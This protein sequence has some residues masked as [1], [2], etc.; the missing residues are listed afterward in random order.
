[1]PPTADWKGGGTAA[2]TDNALPSRQ[3]GG[4][5]GRPMPR[6]RS[7]PNGLRKVGPIAR[8]NAMRRNAVA[9]GFIRRFVAPPDVTTSNRRRLSV[10]AHTHQGRRRFPWLDHQARLPPAS[11]RAFATAVSPSRRCYVLVLSRPLYHTGCYG[12]SYD[13]IRTARVKRKT[14]RAQSFPSC[15]AMDALTLANC[16][17]RWTTYNG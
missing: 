11:T 1:V 2:R 15:R 13:E 16:V 12:L 7:Q 17:Y 10:L 14:G 3:G 4:V 5:F 9:G 6:T 8:R